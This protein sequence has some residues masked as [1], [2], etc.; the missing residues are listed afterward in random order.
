[1]TR[2]LALFTLMIA[3]I[4]SAG[5]ANVPVAFDAGD[6]C[7]VMADEKKDGDNAD[8]KKKGKKVDEE[9]DCE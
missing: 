7:Q 2:L 4:A 1:M 3:S 5:A 9:P 6:S 8:G